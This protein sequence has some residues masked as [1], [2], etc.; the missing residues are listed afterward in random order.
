VVLAGHTDGSVVG[1][2]PGDRS[3]LFTSRLRGSVARL[4]RSGDRLIA[5]SAHGD[6]RELDLGALG[7]PYCRLLREVWRRVGMT[8]E[9]RRAVLR[10]PPSG[11]RC[12]SAP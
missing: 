3:P 1:W 8:W 9:G 4:Q 11:H 10:P 6:R 12:L 5:L 7:A 2:L